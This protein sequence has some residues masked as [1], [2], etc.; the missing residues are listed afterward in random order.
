MT[1]RLAAAL[2]EHRHMRGGVCSGAIPTT[3]G[4]AAR[5]G[6]HLGPHAPE[7]DGAGPAARRSGVAG[8]IHIL[9]HTFCTRTMA[10]V[11]TR[12]IKEMAGHASITTTERYMHLA[13]GSTAGGGA[14]ARAAEL[15]F[16]SYFV[17]GG[18]QSRGASSSWTKS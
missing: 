7:L 12:V 3:A 18:R 14:E 4:Q 15:Q 5:E 13:P 16:W 11:Q 17:R 8:N 10:G 1:S 6:R 9:R 2:R